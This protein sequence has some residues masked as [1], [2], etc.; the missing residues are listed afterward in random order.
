MFR[1]DLLNTSFLYKEM[2]KTTI[3][4]IPVGIYILCFHS[5]SMIHDFYI[6]CAD[7]NIQKRRAQA[8][9]VA[10]LHYLRTSKER[11]RD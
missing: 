9:V 5:T 2:N 6:V 4:L 7:P 3:I 8:Y 1:E 11:S 10:Y